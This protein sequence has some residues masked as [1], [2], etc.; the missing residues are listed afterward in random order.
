M[1]PTC[2]ILK[3]K[4]IQKPVMVYFPSSE[5]IERM[6]EPSDIHLISDKASLEDVAK[7]CDKMVC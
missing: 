5:L 1:I 3:P 7:I 4:D 2:L 6:Q